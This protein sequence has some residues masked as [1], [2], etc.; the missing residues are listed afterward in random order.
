MIILSLAALALGAGPTPNVN[1]SADIAALTEAKLVLWPKYYRENDA[2]GLAGFLAD[3]FVNFGDDGSRE[4]KSEAV[5]WVRANKWGEAEKGFKYTISEIVFYDDD[6]ANVY[7][8]GR[9]DGN[10]PDGP[11]RLA[12]TSANMFVRQDG[13]WKAAFSHTS[14]SRCETQA[15]R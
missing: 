8:I 1:R 9:Y 12:Y 4:T 13:R 11:C 3:G 10:G 7:G 2:D 15:K 14:A 5:A 6:V